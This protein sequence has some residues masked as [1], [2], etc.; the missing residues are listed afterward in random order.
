MRNLT[1]S[2]Y[3][4]SKKDIV[5]NFIL[6]CNRNDLIHITLDMMEPQEVLDVIT[7]SP[8]MKN[9]CI[10]C[11]LVHQSLIRVQRDIDYHDKLK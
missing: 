2:S 10:D 4:I 6:K 1:G 11:D 8:S 5:R 3:L 7:R 9:T